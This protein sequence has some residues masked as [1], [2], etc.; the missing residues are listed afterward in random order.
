MEPVFAV[1]QHKKRFES[2]RVQE[3]LIGDCQLCAV[4]GLV[5]TTANC[6]AVACSLQA[7]GETANVAMTQLLFVLHHRPSTDHKS[8]DSSPA[9]ILTW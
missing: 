9:A 8:T 7:L 6:R 4:F 3:S 5:G 2:A 1:I